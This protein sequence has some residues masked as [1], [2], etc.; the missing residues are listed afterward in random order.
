MQ[1][2]QQGSGPAYSMPQ[3]LMQRSNYPAS[4]QVNAS[5]VPSNPMQPA[6]SRGTNRHASNQLYPEGF[7]NQLLQVQS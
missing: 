1:G 3:Q 7:P 6:G 2:Y 4:S 5:P